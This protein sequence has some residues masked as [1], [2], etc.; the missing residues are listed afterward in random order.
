MT[1]CHFLILSRISTFPFWVQLTLTI[2]AWGTRSLY[3]QNGAPYHRVRAHSFTGVQNSTSVQGAQLDHHHCFRCSNTKVCYLYCILRTTCCSGCVLPVVFVGSEE[4]KCYSILLVDRISGLIPLSTLVNA[5]ETLVLKQSYKN[6]NQLAHR[7][8][9]QT[10]QFICHFE[11]DVKSLH[12]P[13]KS[14]INIFCWKDVF[15][16][17]YFESK[18]DTGKSFFDD[19]RTAF[20]SY[21]QV[22][23]YYQSRLIESIQLVPGPVVLINYQY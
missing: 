11:P 4:N 15:T 9:T 23:I 16:S 22:H 19:V 20:L 8:L 17:I 10:N 3:L 6:N 2:P 7:H 1:S 14:L 5:R 13:L 12:V 21:Q 18:S